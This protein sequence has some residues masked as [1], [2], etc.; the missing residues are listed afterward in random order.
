MADSPVHPTDNS[1][2]AA[3]HIENIPVFDHL[4][5]TEDRVLVDFY[6]DWCGPCRLMAPTID[7]SQ[8]K[9]IAA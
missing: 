8:P 6:A 1:A 2:S 3:E 4:I 9:V 5:S 7:E